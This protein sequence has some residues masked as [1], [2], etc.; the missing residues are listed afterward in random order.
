M[1]YPEES[2]DDEYHLLLNGSIFAP[3]HMPIMLMPGE[4]YCMEIVREL[5]PQLRVLVCFPE[6]MYIYIYIKP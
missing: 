2:S 6:S 3:H 4:D 1:L 5:V